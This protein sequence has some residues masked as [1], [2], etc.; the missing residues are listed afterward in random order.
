MTFRQLADLYIEK[1]AR[2][3]KSTWAEDERS[4]KK[5]VLPAW[6]ELPARSIRK[7]DVRNLIAAVADRAPV[8]ANRLLTR[9][10]TLFRWAVE[11]DYLEASPAL[12]V[13]PPTRSLLSGRS[14]AWDVTS[15]VRR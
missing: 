2:R 11:M 4:I 6:G 7:A 15:M 14:G 1:Y 12:Y 3:N 5:D 10:G 9:L 8:G 13:R